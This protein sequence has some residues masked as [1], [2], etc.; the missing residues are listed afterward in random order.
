[1][2]L[3]FRVYEQTIRT[4]NIPSAVTDDRINSPIDT[5]IGVIENGS[6]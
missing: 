1:M 3:K 4:V 5:K 2:I 6:Y